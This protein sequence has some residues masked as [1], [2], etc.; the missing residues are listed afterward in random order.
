MMKCARCAHENPSVSK[1]CVQCGNHL[2]SRC[3]ACGG[4]LPTGAKFCHQCG[5]AI[6]PTS[7]PAFLAPDTYTPK[8]L[9]ERILVSKAAL[10]GERKHVTVLFAD[11]KASMELL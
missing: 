2:G 11:V 6:V 8:H 10:E 4:E 3:A 5:Q 7:A 1:F 9:A